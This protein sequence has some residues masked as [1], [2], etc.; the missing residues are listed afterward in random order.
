MPI[1]VLGS[2]IHAHCLGIDS[3]P[4]LGDSI[5]AQSLWSDFGG[6][7]LN[8]ALGL[9]KLGLNVNMLLAVGKD[10][11]GQGLHLYLQTQG[12]ATQGLITVAGRSGFGV[13]LISSTGE[14]VIIIYPGANY[15]LS[16]QHVQQAAASLQQSRLVC[17]QFEILDEPIL[18]AFRFAQQAGIKTLLNPSPWRVISPALLALTNILVLNRTEAAQ[19]FDLDLRHTIDWQTVLPN[20]AWQGELLVVTLGAQGCVAY[21]A[22]HGYHTCPAWPI[23]QMDATGAGDAFTVGLMYALTQGQT[24]A[25]ALTLATAC[26]AIVASQRG[27]AQALPDSARLQVFMRS[28]DSNAR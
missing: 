8:L 16:A 2:Y 7:G 9:H 14:N 26:G 22:T 13:G 21:H 20:G 25:Q 11:E 19:F 24:L 1:T 12:L 17:A 10:A 4:Q 23:Q 27:V 5:S 18:E 28:L 3:L 15:L 6:K